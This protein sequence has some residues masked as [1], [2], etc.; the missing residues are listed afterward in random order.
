MRWMLLFIALQRFQ[1]ARWRVEQS[2][3]ITLVLKRELEEE[4]GV[5]RGVRCHTA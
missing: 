4:T 1:P 2:E 5:G 3:G